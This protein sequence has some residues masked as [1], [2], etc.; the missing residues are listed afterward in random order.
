MAAR[1]VSGKLDGDATLLTSWQLAHTTLSE[2]NNL[3]DASDSV[4][5]ANKSMQQFQTDYFLPDQTAAGIKP[6]RGKL[7]GALGEIQQASEMEIDLC[8]KALGQI[9]ALITLRT[10]ALAAASADQRP[11]RTRESSTA[12]QTSTSTAAQSGK[13]VPVASPATNG[14]LTLVLPARGALQARIQK[15]LPLHKGRKV[16]FR[17]PSSQNGKASVTPPGA[18]PGSYEEGA[19]ILALV[20]EAEKK[21]KYIVQDIEGEDGQDPP[22]YTTTIR[23]LIPLPVINVSPSDPSHISN[24]PEYKSGSTVLALFPDTTSFYK[25]VV[26]ATPK[27]IQT[28]GLRTA[29]AAAKKVPSYELRFDDDQN[30]TRHVAAD[31]VIDFPNY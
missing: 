25:A 17:V 21:D 8:K 31:F 18:E 23:S 11:K 15:Q 13:S 12:P 29:P 1:R 19:W 3:P 6:L 7:K 4:T 27:E 28:S 2:L 22:V 24:Y 5:R 16:A 9:Q 14:G 10:D 20:H 26:V 30:Q